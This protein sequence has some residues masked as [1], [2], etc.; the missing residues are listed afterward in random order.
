MNRY[1][2]NSKFQTTYFEDLFILSIGVSKILQTVRIIFWNLFGFFD[3]NIENSCKYE[4]FC[5]LS[6]FFRANNIEKSRTAVA[7]FRSERRKFFEV[8]IIFPTCVFSSE[9]VTSKILPSSN[10]RN[11]SFFFFRLRRQK[12][13]QLKKIIRTRSEEKQARKIIRT[14]TDFRRSDE[15]KKR[16]STKKNSNFEEFVN[17]TL[18]KNKE[19][20]K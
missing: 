15:K 6:D 16:S 17:V 2:K 20:E 12:F 14:W 19:S 13:F 7:F 10:L 18:G 4:L 11:E 9:S 5:G 1:V 8:R 3:R